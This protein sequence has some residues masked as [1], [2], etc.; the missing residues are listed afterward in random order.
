M[1][2]ALG[3]ATSL[4]VLVGLVIT[5]L[6]QYPE[7]NVPDPIY[8]ALDR[9]GPAVAWA[10]RLVGFVA[11]FGLISVLLVALIAQ[12]R[13][14]YAM[15]RDGLLPQWFARISRRTGVPDRSTIATSL[16]AAFA[17][18]MLPLGL[19][20]QLISI[21]TLLAFAVVCAGVAVLRIRQPEA[22]RPFK[23]P[24]GLWTAGA[25][26][27][28]CV[29]LMLSLPLNTWLRPAG[30]LLLGGA[31]YWFYGSRHSTLQHEPRD[32]TLRRESRA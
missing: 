27:L 18:G 12:A 17:A 25:G 3:I 20:G 30:W 11:V 7:L 23:A 28:S 14:C 5:G 6:V 32:P 24:L 15:G 8:L 19:L 9:A 16:V 31:I 26:V 10:K 21:G 1:L 2:L 13:I 29:W 4:Y 22:P